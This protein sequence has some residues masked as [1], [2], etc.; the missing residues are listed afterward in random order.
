MNKLAMCGLTVAFAGLSYAADFSGKLLDAACYNQ[1]M[2]NAPPPD[3]NSKS[4]V[5]VRTPDSIAETCAPTALT[6]TFAFMNL[7]G[8][9]YKFENASDGKAE[10]AV[11]SGALVR[12]KEGDVRV[13]LS[14][15]IRG[16]EMMVRS[17]EPDT[18][19]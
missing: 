5:P 15:D 2:R 18:H 12:D 19:D 11:Q 4:D 16:D 17:V 8:K 13:K 14:G 3:I 1:V 7:D 6:T 10:S 9:I